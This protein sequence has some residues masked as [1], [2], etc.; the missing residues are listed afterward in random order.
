MVDTTELIIN[1]TGTS[2]G[3]FTSAG[4]V[5]VNY[6]YNPS[7]R[8]F[9]SIYADGGR[10][11]YTLSGSPTAHTPGGDAIVNVTGNTITATDQAA[12][13]SANVRGGVGSDGGDAQIS[14]ANFDIDVQTFEMFLTAQGGNAN[15][16]GTDG[17]ANIT[18]ADTTIGIAGLSFTVGLTASSFATG[19]AASGTSSL[20][21]ERNHWSGNDGFNLFGL[22]FTTNENDSTISSSMAV[23]MNDNDI[24]LGGSTDILTIQVLRGAH[25]VLSGNVF[26][27]GDGFDLLGFESDNGVT[28]NLPNDGFTNFEY[29]Y[30]S[31]GD[32]I[33]T[34][35]DG[36]TVFTP[37][38]GTNVVF[39]N[40]GNDTFILNF[41]TDDY[42]GGTGTDTLDLS[43][44]SVGA[45]V[46]LWTSTA[47]ADGTAHLSSIENVLGTP[48]DDVIEGD[49]FDNE[50]IGG[51]G[52]DRL[53]GMGGFNL[54]E[55]GLGD[56]AIYGSAGNDTAVYGR[57]TEVVGN[58][59]TD[60]VTISLW[61][62]VLPQNT[63]IFGWDT[64]IGP[65]ENAW[66]TN[67]QDRIAGSDYDNV[68][69]GFAAD[70]VLLGL[71]GSDRLSGGEGNDIIDGGAGVDQML[72]NL[73]DDTYY[74]D[75]S[76]DETIEESGGGYDRVISTVS[77]A[78]R[79]FEEEL[80]LQGPLAIN[81]RGTNLNNVI[82][83]NAANNMI[84]GLMGSDLMFGGG[85][86]D[87]YFADTPGDIA[88]ENPD[89]GVDLVIANSGY[90]LFANVE[91]LTLAENFD[92]FGL[93][94]FIE[95]LLGSFFDFN[96]DFFGVG[97]ALDNEI[98]GNSGNNL[99]LGGDGND[100]IF[101]GGGADSI[102]GE[103]GN[104]QLHGDDGID[105]IAG[106]AGS[107]RI[108]GGAA[109]DALFG[110]DGD[111][112]LDG[113]NSFDT[114]I[115]VGGAGND[116][117]YAISG[118][119][120]PDYDLLDGGAGDDIYWVDT[121]DDLTFEAIGGGIDTVHA[122]VNVANAGVY[123]WANV[124]NLVL[125]GTTTF[126]VGNEL[127]NQLTGNASVNLL[128]GG[129]GQDTLN[130]MGGNDVLFGEGG[131][132]TFVFTAG[133]G[134]D[135]IGDFTRGQD[136]IDIS[137]FGFSFAQAQANFIQ[138]GNVGAINLGNGDF[139]VLH[140]VTMSTLTATDFI[141][142]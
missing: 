126:G 139:I 106:G 118:Q 3:Q 22:L 107:D 140:N 40:G 33:F 96:V 77:F 142:G 123:L 36:S 49:L 11:S 104:D 117:L 18:I 138:N 48:W 64:L 99:L 58:V 47:T 108:S 61:F 85:G 79:G 92:P 43:G 109:A 82:V 42:D 73:G 113:G 84:D 44:S 62:E 57:G 128:L 46:R 26:D 25:L 59:V 10:G 90:Y 89:E 52:N 32:D 66:G 110:E 111:D 55:G 37:N 134:G 16:S 60:G 91:N 141:F 30:G 51:D 122:A 27:G 13:L 132:D 74:V 50:L 39:G 56:D 2:A 20:L 53:D 116:T 65:I 72:G 98:R 76:R 131:N 54:L 105:F 115:L 127:D 7:S 68:L 119:A 94:N 137:A 1:E 120:N 112:Y 81:A 136:K 31:R 135:V 103:A 23:T 21:I 67:A 129:A 78:L 86:D 130:G 34:D 8:P 70:D 80:Y 125:E 15:G 45:E 19:S 69:L 63:G 4:N 124:E 83:G 29:V 102:F 95:Q 88:F 9:V 28:I 38:G 12:D 17:N 41:G 97:N 35:G 100:Q 71:G 121:G 133:T 6:T 24:R 114:D 75:D 93:G 87:T 5:A 14:I 101:G